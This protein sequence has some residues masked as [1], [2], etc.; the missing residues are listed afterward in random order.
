MYYPAYMSR[1]DTTKPMVLY[2][3]FWGNPCEL[4]QE[5]GDKNTHF[6]E[7]TFF[8]LWHGGQVKPLLEKSVLNHHWD[9]FPS[10]CKEFVLNRQ[11]FSHQTCV[12]K[13]SF[14]R[15]CYYYY[16]KWVNFDWLPGA[17]QA[18]FSLL[19]LAG[20]EEKIRGKN[21]MSW[22]QSSLIKQKKKSQKLHA[23]TKENQRRFILYLP[24]TDDFQICRALACVEVC[25]E[26]IYLN[27]ENLPIFLL[28]FSD[29]HEVTRHKIWLW[30]VWVSY[31]T[32]VPFPNSFIPSLRVFGQDEGQPWCCVSAET[33]VHLHLHFRHTYK[34]QHPV[35]YC[36][37][38]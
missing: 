3:I 25:L 34:A 37:E 33:L 5:Q 15:W 28:D 12:W 4:F 9:I 20:R 11:V 1:L 38:R 31:L 2:N 24:S 36:E 29:E 6:W 19:L 27:N 7:H 14:V 17:H 16:L 32:C 30:P 22:D 13:M 26:E 21:L 23:E 18:C 8:F 10:S 35:G